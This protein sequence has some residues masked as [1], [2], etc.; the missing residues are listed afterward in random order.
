MALLGGGGLIDTRALTKPQRF[1]GKEEEWRDW[2]FQFEAYAGLLGHG[3][4]G[5]MEQAGVLT[6]NMH[7]IGVLTQDLA[8][9]SRSLYFLLAQLLAG[10]ALTILRA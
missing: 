7:P 9:L 4:L 8:D 3:L 2:C 6:G 1:S 10:K 5:H